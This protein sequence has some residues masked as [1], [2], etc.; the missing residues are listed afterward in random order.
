M[1]KIILGLDLDG[2]LYDWHS[3]VFTYFQY[4]CNYCG[5]YRTFWMEYFPSMSAE[6]HEYIVSLP[7]LYETQVPLQSTMNFLAFA[8][9]NAND[10]YYI[11]HRPRE[12]E[13]VTRRYFK[14]YDFPC[15]DNLFMTGD[16][17]NMCRYLGIT[18]F[19]DDHVKHVDS[20]KRVSSSYL[21]SKVYNRDFQDGMNVVSSLREF[22]EIVFK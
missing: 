6:W 17:A 21:M 4:E 1:E 20:V 18:H 10:V 14:K 16:K 9:E 22:K 13:N 12:V 7:F 11:T 8:K 15:Q 19:L 3:A 5:D 2:V